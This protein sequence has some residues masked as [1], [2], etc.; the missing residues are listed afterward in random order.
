MPAFRSLMVVLLVLLAGCALVPWP[1][2]LSP[3]VNLAH[4]ELTRAD[5][6]EQRYRILLR[7]QN[8]NPFSLPIR[9]LAF[10]VHVD[11]RR[12]LRGVSD[13]AVTI[14]AYG[15]EVLE[16]QGV[17]TLGSVVDQLRALARGPDVVRYRVSGHFVLLDRSGRWH[18][19]N[20]GEFPLFPERH[21][22]P[23]D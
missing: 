3:D 2:P 18:F 11:G 23:P 6:L 17:S 8:P 15:E 7:V 9:G 22:D 13:T 12:F 14:P 21:L 5:L 1:R 19:E 10:Q 16:V 4:L 20:L